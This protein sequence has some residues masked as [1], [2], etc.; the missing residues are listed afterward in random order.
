MINPRDYAKG[1]GERVNPIHLK[2]RIAKRGSRA[3]PEE[4]AEVLEQISR[5][6]KAPEGWKF[7]AIDWQHPK[8]GGGSGGAMDMQA[9]HALIRHMGGDL[10]VSPA[11]RTR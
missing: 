6:G 3:T 9:F 11:K 1:R 10:Q 2:I 8:G 5:T 7:F 4:I